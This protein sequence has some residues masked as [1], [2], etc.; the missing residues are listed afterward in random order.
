MPKTYEELCE[1]MPGG[2]SSPVRT[3]K[4][5]DAPTFV[6]SKGAGDLIYNS[7]GKPFIDYCCSWGSLIHGHAHPKILEAVKK[8]IDLGTSF[9]MTTAIEGELASEIIKN[10]PNIEKVRFVNSGTE[11]TMTAARLARGYTGKNKIVKFIGNYH[12][13]SDPFLVAAGSGVAGLT[14]TS[15]SLGVPPGAVEDTICLPYNDI[16]A[17]KICYDDVAAIIIEPVAGNMGVVPADDH[18]IHFLRDTG[19]LLIFDEVITGFRVG[20]HGAQELYNV[21]ADIVC[22]GKVIGGGF[23]IAAV[24]ST[25]EIMSHLAPQGQIYQAGTLSGNP[26]AVQAGLTALQMLNEPFYDELEEKANIVTEA[27]PG[28]VQQVGSMFCFFFGEGQVRNFEDAQA[29]DMEAFNKFYRYMY[30]NGVLL[31]PSPYESWFVS[32]AHTT[33]HLEQTAELIRRYFL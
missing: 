2:V 13:H 12:G 32:A 9:G 15:S 1:V 24:A 21:K 8:R 29:Q 4:N 28:V 30:D 7:D 31:P 5:A 3:F 27:F 33:E 23:P 14:P 22:L 18:F 6:A 19:A 20:L 25:D 17:A 26:V 16:E 10:V 11:A